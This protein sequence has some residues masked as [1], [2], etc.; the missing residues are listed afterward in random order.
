MCFNDDG[1]IKEGSSCYDY[2]HY[3]TGWTDKVKV[4]GT[5]SECNGSI[6]GV[7]SESEYPI[8]SGSWKI[9]YENSNDYGIQYLENVLVEK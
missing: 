4:T 5:C 7:L 6:Y 3:P 1:T 2:P 9:D 8:F